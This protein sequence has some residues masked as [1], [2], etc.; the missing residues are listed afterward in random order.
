LLLSLI[1][2]IEEGFEIIKKRTVATLRE[3]VDALVK[4]SIYS[5]ASLEQARAFVEHTSHW[6]ASQLELPQPALPSD[7]DESD[8]YLRQLRQDTKSF[9][10]GWRFILGLAILWVITSLVWA[11][12]SFTLWSG[13][14]ATLG[15]AVGVVIAAALSIFCGALWRR[16][17]WQR[18]RQS[19]QTWRGH[20]NEKH[21]APIVG[22]LYRE[23][24]AA[25]SEILSWAKGEQES[26]ESFFR[27]L[28]QS[29]TALSEKVKHIFATPAVG[30]VVDEPYA[31]MF[32]GSI[33]T[34]PQQ[35]SRLFTS[36]EL[37][38]WR[39]CDPDK[40]VWETENIVTESMAARIRGLSVLEV[41][42][43]REK[44]KLKYNQAHSLTEGNDVMA[45]FLRQAAPYG[46]YF[47]DIG[48]VLPIRT[49]VVIFNPEPS[50]EEV[51][52]NRIPAVVPMVSEWD[53]LRMVC[54]Q[55]RQAIQL[56]TLEAMALG[57]E[58]TSSKPT[59]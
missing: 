21:A 44:A 38:N 58:C 4:E 11:G 37:A 24:A 20:I 5:A 53:P 6:M 39:E 2:A 54:L 48:S 27:A 31:K 56:H 33:D 14:V 32:Y 1:K 29:R 52:K 9:P 40:L 35:F 22:L 16:L 45:W 36:G 13:S 8:Q 47:S 10:R 23:L 59:A 18:L 15:T 49:I 43:E 17:S 41:I 12:I 26:I 55:V 28:E 42:R 57:K 3:A 46:R 7:Q 19:S 34:D 50:V 30:W 25:K 51:L